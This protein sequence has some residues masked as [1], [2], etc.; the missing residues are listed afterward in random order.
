VPILEDLGEMRDESR[1]KEKFELSLDGTQ[2]AS[3]VVGALIVLGVVF[4]VGLDVGK[5]LALRQ[6]PPGARSADP[7]AALD[8]PVPPDPKEPSPRLSYH[9]ALT[10]DQP[11][12]HPSPPAVRPPPVVPAPAPVAAP[13]PPPVAAADPSEK[14]A[15]KPVKPAAPPPAPTPSNDEAE[16]PPV[17]DAKPKPVAALP[18]AGPAVDRTSGSTTERAFAIQVG[19]SQDL[20]EANRIAERFKTYRP[21]IVTAEVPGKG[22]W[23]RVRVGAFENRGDASR[24][25]VDLT[26]ETGASGFITPTH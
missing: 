22:R 1:V 14:V 15:E 9:E 7:L 23:Y 3:I 18:V 11:V 10:K 25:L 20:A 26:R 17:A 8:S 16:D 6:Q 2:V 21:R 12:H 24:Y 4:V 5:Q 13:A 19:A